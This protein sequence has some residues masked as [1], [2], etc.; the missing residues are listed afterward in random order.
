MGLPRTTSRRGS[1]LDIFLACTDVIIFASMI[2]VLICP[3]KYESSYFAL[4]ALSLLQ[5]IGIK[6]NGE[7]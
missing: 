2:R 4:L 1:G 3:L 6:Q 5:S 7:R